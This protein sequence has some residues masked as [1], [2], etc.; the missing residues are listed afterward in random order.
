MPT[1]KYDTLKVERLPDGADSSYRLHG[2]PHGEDFRE[3][4]SYDQLEASWLK[5]EGVAFA[6]SS[7]EF[8]EYG[9]PILVEQK[10]DGGATRISFDQ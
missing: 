1:H 6:C 3:E 7:A 2:L 8:G 10:T 4:A 9:T 5:V